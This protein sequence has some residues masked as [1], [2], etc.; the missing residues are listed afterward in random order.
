MSKPLDERYFVWLY[1]QVADAEER[2]PSKT[3]W[4]LL[5]KLYAKEFFWIVPNDDNR[6]EDGRYLRLEFL[7]REAIQNVDN[8]W[9]HMGC[10]MLELMIG[11]SRKLS[12]VAEGEPQIWFW[13]LVENLGL[14]E[15][16]DNRRLPN[17]LIDNRLNEVI[18]RTYKRNGHGGFFPL[19][20]T[21]HDQRDVEI[22]MQMNEYI[23]E[24]QLI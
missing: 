3:Y 19:N 9:L 7:D 2:H 21:R 13:T 6:I 11:L 5:R 23:L 22:W 10:S 12:F 14:E 16:N 20:K 4:G 24:L 18:W 1:S 17:M 15:F 8:D